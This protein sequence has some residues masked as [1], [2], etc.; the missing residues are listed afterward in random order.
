[1][2]Q[3]QPERKNK[4]SSILLLAF[5]IAALVLVALSVALS[6]YQGLLQLVAAIFLSADI[7]IFHMYFRRAFIYRVASSRDEDELPIFTVS[8]VVGKNS[9]V[10]CRFSLDDLVKVEKYSKK[11]KKGLGKHYNYCI[12]IAPC[13]AYVL[14]FESGGQREAIIL[15]PDEKLLSIFN[16]CI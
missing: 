10:L 7:F 15:S 13:D 6:K 3:F 16:S 11:I 9:T 5:G 1:M 12:D 14:F 4:I 8:E 2:Y